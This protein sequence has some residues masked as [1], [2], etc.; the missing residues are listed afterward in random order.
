MTTVVVAWTSVRVGV[1]TLRISAR[2]S[3]RKLLSRS[4]CALS[5]SRPVVCWSV[6]AIVFAMLLPRNFLLIKTGESNVALPA[7]LPPG[8]GRAGKTGGGAR[9]RTEKFGFGD[10]Q[11]NR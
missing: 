1:T 6:T 11:F 3:L 4:G 9:I 8:L 5:R 2:T 7:M 10:R